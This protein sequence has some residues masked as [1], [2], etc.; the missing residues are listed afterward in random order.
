M[1]AAATATTPTHQ[2][3]QMPG[4]QTRLNTEEEQALLRV[5][6]EANGL[7][8]GPQAE[9]FEKEFTAFI[10]CADAAAL[11]SCSAA[12]ELAA[13]FSELKPGDEVIMPAHTF[14]ASAVPFG[15][16]GATLR[17]ADIDRDT[18]VV[19]AATIKP[20]IT[21]RTRAVVVVH[22]YGLAAD[23]DPIMALAERHNLLVIEDCAQSPGARYKSRRVGS[24]GHF[25]CFS[26]HSH[27]NMTTLGE[28]GMLT[29]RDKAHG[30]AARRM[31]WMGYWPFEY[32]RKQYWKPAMSDVVEPIPG[33]WPVNYCM[34]E[35]NAAVG[36]LLLRRLDAINAQRR[37]QAAR[38]REA[39]AD[40]PELSFQT[41]SP[42][43][44]HVYHLLAARYD[45]AP[46]GKTRDDLMGLLFDTYKLKCIVQYPPL[47]RMELFRKFGFADADVPES[48]RFFDNMVSFPW[49]SNMGDEVI[50]DI[51]ARVRSA[52]DDLRGG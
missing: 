36:R 27:K 44:E 21:K 2:L 32:E 1:T 5:L 49:W 28:G 6:R 45:G 31:R 47:Q 39:L 16:T 22:L 12:L 46:Y 29:V 34:G 43:C 14:V 25:G 33:R 40:Y 42:D 17:W 41:E 4:V 11:S 52:L 13:I 15:R 50:D 24:I 19:S 18:R 51:T 8:T 20:L 9:G 26:F 48:D 37:A 23:M 35:P 30:R 38:F 3:I 7:A 10:G